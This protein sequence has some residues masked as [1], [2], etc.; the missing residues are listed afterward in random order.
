MKKMF[1]A[2]LASAT[3][4]FG[5]EIT[6]FAAANTT[7][8]FGDLIREFNAKNPDIKVNVTLGASGGLVT[9][10]QNGAPADIFMAA[11]MSFA[12]KAYDTGFALNKPVVYARGALAIFSIR[13]LDFKKGINVVLGLKTISIA[14]PQTAPYG[15]ASIEALKNAK[16]F[17][18]VSKNIIYTQKIS[19]TL[20]QAL[21]AADAGFIAASSLYDSKM[22]KYKEG[23]NYIFVDPSLYTPID[24]GMIIT[25]RA[26]NNAEARAFYDFILSQEGREI[27]KKYG[28]NLPQ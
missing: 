17:D 13:D 23:I 11:D 15:K 12:Q 8:A 14:N 6:V 16:I 10:I 24:Q 25:K 22:A 26:Q 19:E 7:Y 28:Y 4:L 5:G 3:I 18:E 27:F 21:S 2:I 9:Q 20:S 1:F